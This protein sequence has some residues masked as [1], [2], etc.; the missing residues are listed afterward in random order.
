MSGN[1]IVLEYPLLSWRILGDEDGVGRGSGRS[2][3]RR[4]WRFLP[5]GGGFG[6]VIGIGLLLGLMLGS[7]FRGALMGGDADGFREVLRSVKDLDGTA[8]VPFPVLLCRRMLILL[9]FGALGLTR[10]ARTCYGLALGC[11]G[12]SCGSLLS[13]MAW[14]CGARGILAALC[15]FFPQYLIYVPVMGL[16]YGRVLGVGRP[17]GGRGRMGL[18][19]GGVLRYVMFLLLLAALLFFGILLEAYVNP[20]LIKKIIT[21]L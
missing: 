17:D 4:K 18:E 13:V 10:G 6:I 9:F 3:R 8:I 19:R 5:G 16:L 2:M 1:G 7:L 21:I 12:T 14:S 11:F 20:I 15:F